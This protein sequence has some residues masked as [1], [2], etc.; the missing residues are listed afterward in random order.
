VPALGYEEVGR[1][2]VAVNDAFGVGGVKRVGNIEGQLY[3]RLR[4]HRPTSDAMLQG[5]P[6][7]KL[8]GDEGLAVL[9]PDG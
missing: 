4:F 5:Q 3:T 9:L 1:F 7:Q 2:D 6:I 8:H